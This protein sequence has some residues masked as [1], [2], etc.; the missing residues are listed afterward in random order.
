MCATIKWRDL[1]MFA[2][3][4][5]ESTILYIPHFQL[6]EPFSLDFRLLL[7]WNENLTRFLILSWFFS[8]FSFGFG[9]KSAFY[10]DR[11]QTPTDCDVYR[12]TLIS[13]ATSGMTLF[14]YMCTRLCAR[15]CMHVSGAYPCVLVF[16]H[17]ILHGTTHSALVCLDYQFDLL[18]NW[19]WIH[20]KR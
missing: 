13:V 12:C 17:T 11:D 3:K 5:K 1:Y 18:V 6:N 8:E 20:L 4:E 2:C 7:G 19:N 15:V 10:C 16:A 14:K 9:E